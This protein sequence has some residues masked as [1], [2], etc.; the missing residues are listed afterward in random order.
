MKVRRGTTRTV[1]LTKKYAI[2]IARFWH[3]MKGHRWKMFLR[4]I[5][6]NIDE[7]FWWKC[8]YKREKLCPVV[9]KSPLGVILVM[10]KATPLKESEYDKDAFACTF[11]NL[12]LDNK[13]ENFG[14]IENKVV[15]VDYADSRYMCSDCSNCFKN[16]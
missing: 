2:K 4:G 14:K 11:E 1:I 13:I 9:W 8:E 15:L 10:K 7:K 16:R 5:L 12:S 6:A 3:S